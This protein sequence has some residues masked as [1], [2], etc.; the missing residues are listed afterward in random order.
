MVKAII[1][2]GA[3]GI[4]LAGWRLAAVE[5]A[6]PV[7]V[8]PASSVTPAQIPFG[9]PAF[10]AL[11]D[12]SYRVAGNGTSADFFSWWD[13]ALVSSTGG[14][15][16]A[17]IDGAKARLATATDKNET[18]RLLGEEMHGIIKKTIRK[19]SLDRGYEFANVPILNERQCLLQATL[20]AS[21]LQAAGVNA[22]LVMVWS[23]EQGQT[24]NLG[25]VATIETLDDGSR[26]LVDASEPYPHAKH[27]GLFML[28]PKS[29]SYAFVNVSYDDAGKI[30]GYSRA[31]DHG[32]VDGSTLLPLDRAYVRSQFDFY[33]GE[34]SIGGLL[35]KNK[36]AAGLANSEQFLRSSLHESPDNPLAAF[37]LARVYAM[38][39]RPDLARSTL[40]KALALYRQFGWV[41]PGAPGVLGSAN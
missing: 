40:A 39:N 27:L 28:N 17:W 33:R 36:T 37:S 8:P 9:G 18:E 32:V 5:Q 20:I 2:C 25:H 21:M 11:V 31:S 23:N 26:F 24:S 15:A 22:G 6:P 29:R 35:A 19:F 16:Q 38:E 3:V 41:P 1:L 4:A 7:K 10:K 14:D 12:D 34:R 13:Q 30:T